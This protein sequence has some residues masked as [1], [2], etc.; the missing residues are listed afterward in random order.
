MAERERES[1]Q[2]VVRKDEGGTG[3]GSGYYKNQ[4]KKYMIGSKERVRVVLL[5]D[6]CAVCVFSLLE[7]IDVYKTERDNT[8]ILFT[9]DDGVAHLLVVT[10]ATRWKQG[11]GG[12][13]TSRTPNKKG[14]GK[15]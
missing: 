12:N 8:H 2:M 6:V 4:K 1:V 5:L 15:G 9:D 7:I 14:V 10:L 11:G 13:G 3:D